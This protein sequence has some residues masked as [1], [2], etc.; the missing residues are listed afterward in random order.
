MQMVVYTI[1]IKRQA[2]RKLKSLSPDDRLRITDK[3]RQLGINPDNPILDVKKLEGQPFYRLRVGQWR[4][5]YDRQ[6]VLKIIS[7]EKIKPRGD[8]Y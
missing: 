1:I 5:I 7:V 8:A 3:I 2:Q 4:I 6:E